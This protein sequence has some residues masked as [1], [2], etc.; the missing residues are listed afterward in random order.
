[1]LCHVIA[2]LRSYTIKISQIEES[3]I[4]FQDVMTYNGNYITLRFEIFQVSYVKVN[5]NFE[6]EILIIFLFIS[7]NSCFGCSKEPSH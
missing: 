4:Q 7:L 3:D 2:S 6:C 5:N 1:M